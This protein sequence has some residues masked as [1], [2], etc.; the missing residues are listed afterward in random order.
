MK[1]IWEGSRSL[2]HKLSLLTDS[3]HACYSSYDFP[4][5]SAPL[6]EIVPRYFEPISC[7]RA[8]IIICRTNEA[9]RLI[10]IITRVATMRPAS[11]LTD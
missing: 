7:K 11:S 5:I 2:S 6:R 9:T 8:P 1:W 10:S 3:I 4:A